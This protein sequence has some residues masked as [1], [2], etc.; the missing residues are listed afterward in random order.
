[1][2]K[3]NF[4]AANVEP[5]TPMD[6]LPAGKYLCMAIASELKLTK[7]K[8]GEY[9]QITFEVLEGQFKSRKIFERLNIRNSNKTAEDI[10]Q[11]QLSAL[12]HAVGVIELDDSEQLHNIPVTLEVSID[13]AKGDYAASNRV[14]GYTA[15]GGSPVH[16]QAVGQAAAERSTPAAAAPAASGNTPVWKKKAA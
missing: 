10:A 6:V 16:R 3:L 12:C 4:N 2:A 7:D 15:A 9:L 11:R 1:M 14:K 8:N 13:P 5:S